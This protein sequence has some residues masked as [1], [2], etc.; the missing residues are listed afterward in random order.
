MKLSF[1]SF[2]L[3]L[4]LALSAQAVD[5][6]QSKFTQVVNDVKVVTLP[7]KTQKPA[8]VN[9]VFRM[10]DIVRTGP[11]SRAE[12]VADD[13]T[14][15]RVGANTIFS[16]DAAN[17]TIDLE[18]GSLL[19]HSPKGKGGGQIK[20]GSASAAVLGTTI[21]VSS[22]PDGGFKIL[23]LE[24]KAKITLANGETEIVSAGQEVFV[25]PGGQLSPIINFRLDTLVAESKLVGGFNDALPSL[26]QIRTEVSHQ[27]KLIVNGEA[28]D[29]GL[30]VG[31]GATGTTIEAVD[32]ISLPQNFEAPVGALSPDA[33]SRD[34]L[35]D[36]PHLDSFGAHL[37]PMPTTVS[38]PGLSGTFVGLFG[39]DINFDAGL[40]TVDLF[41]FDSLS[42]FTFLASR[43]INIG[44]S[45]DFFGSKSANLSLVALGS[46]NIADD[47]TLSYNGPGFFLQSGN[48]MSYD[49]V[50]FENFNG[51]IDLKTAGNMSLRNC[52]VAGDSVNLTAG[53]DLT[54]HNTT[55]QANGGFAASAKQHTQVAVTTGTVTLTAQSGS[56]IVNSSTFYGN[57]LNARA[58]GMIN[59]N[60]VNLSSLSMIN[61]AAHTITLE[62]INFASGSIVNLK[63]FYGLLAANPNTGL[64]PVAGYVNFVNNVNY[65]G[66]PAQN[67]VNPVSGSGIF[68]SKK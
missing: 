53:N 10:P 12:L 31:D 64:S 35:I 62:N 36:S 21:I 25:L 65:G 15:T 57:T 51:L 42:D 58:A 40:Q 61:L 9:D 14:I 59:M 43:N 20:T 4:T 26:D 60:G 22:T 44:N 18:K 50:A 23:V 46:I 19:F 24:G 55:L 48:A 5:L 52:N 13:K 8:V 28:Q 41:P 16:F 17:R 47:I 30:L 37:F 45:I 34:V 56:L 66:Q 38:G 33:L 49:T 2:A 27:E 7:D 29:T 6:K 68:I 1:T 63:S 32:P 39:R 54:L 3:V 67:F 11:A